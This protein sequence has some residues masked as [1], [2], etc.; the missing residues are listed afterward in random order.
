MLKSYHRFVKPAHTE[1]VRPTMKYA[2]I[3]IP[4]GRSEASI[5]KNNIGVSFIVHNL[6]HH[7]VKA[8]YEIVVPASDLL[9]MCE[10]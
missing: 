2:D 4:R 9:E 6:E 10:V 8:G 5:E 7:L 3:I 1:F